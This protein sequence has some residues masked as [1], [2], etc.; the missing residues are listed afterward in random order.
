MDVKTLDELKTMSI[1]DLCVY[2]DAYQKQQQEIV[3]ALT[4]E[5]EE[6]LS[7]IESD[8]KATLG[9]ILGMTAPTQKAV[10]QDT[11]DISCLVK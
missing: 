10:E 5:K 1:D 2:V 4:K 9:A 6:L 3:T 8:K 11:F 7:K